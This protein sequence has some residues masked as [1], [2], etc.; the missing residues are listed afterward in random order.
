MAWQDEALTIAVCNRQCIIR[1]RPETLLMG[2]ARTRALEDSIRRSV[3]C[4][5]S[6]Q[7]EGVLTRTSLTPARDPR[8]AQALFLD[9]NLIPVSR[10]HASG[11]RVVQP[12][13]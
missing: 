7:R 6:I 3:H 4:Q 11:R 9:S 2:A 12:P 8:A 1:I 13:L 10:S 5:S